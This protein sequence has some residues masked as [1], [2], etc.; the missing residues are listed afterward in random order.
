MGWQLRYLHSLDELRGAATAWDDLWYRSGSAAPV[1]RA[2]LIAQWVESFDTQAAFHAAVVEEDG[3]F[4]AALPLV[5]GRKAKLISTGLFPRNDWCRCG[6]LL[7]DPAAGTEALDVLIQ[8]LRRLPWS[9]TWLDGVPLEQPQ[10]REFMISLGR[11]KL[12]S[13]SH[14]QA[15]VGVVDCTGDW[16]E[17]QAAWSG[18]HR[19]HMRKAARKAESEGGVELQVVREFASPEEV[20]ELVR[21]GFEVEDRS[22]KGSGTNSSVL[23]TPGLLDYFTR[24]AQQ[25]AE[26]DQLQL[27][28]LEFN[29]EPIAFEFGW[30]A[31]GVYFT[32]KVG[33]DESF[34][35]FSPGQLLRYE[36]YERSHA[37]RNVHLVDFAGELSDATAKWTTGTY[38]VSRLVFGN[39]SLFSRALL[40]GYVRLRNFRTASE[41][42]ATEADA[43]TPAEPS[44]QECPAS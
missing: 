34:G 21:R 33:Y 30:L 37:E 25:L 42:A 23:K 31:K 20:A 7:W 9:L 19:R 35:R 18:N 16:Q 3:Q 29:G 41:A 38:P 43:A 27:V 6:D 44:L 8:G 12:L 14:A 26:W 2:E 39:G 40:S 15:T 11:A 13:H 1:A 32:P 36:L 28:F 17:F 10:W 4:V 5:G 22:W 24:Q